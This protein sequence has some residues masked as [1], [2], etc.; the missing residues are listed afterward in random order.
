MAQ[1][2][3][4]FVNYSAMGRHEVRFDRWMKNEM[5]L[6]L[7]LRFD[8]CEQLIRLNVPTLFVSLANDENSSSCSTLPRYGEPAKLFV[9][10]STLIRCF[11]IS[12]YCRSK[13]VRLNRFLFSKKIRSITS[14][15]EWS[16]TIAEPV[17]HARKRSDM[18]DARRHCWT[19]LQTRFFSQENCRRFRQ[20]WRFTSSS[21]FSSLGKRWNY[22]N[23]SEWNDDFGNSKYLNRYVFNSIFF[24][25]SCPFITRMI[26]VFI[27]MFFTLF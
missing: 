1:Y 7:C 2:F 6:F 8:Q 3:Q 5:K 15:L 11:D 26:F 12:I 25:F 14:I 16:K 20:L 17:L 27:S 23:Y 22:V 9:I 10:L 13:E 4:F 24:D 21:A 19:H 18:F